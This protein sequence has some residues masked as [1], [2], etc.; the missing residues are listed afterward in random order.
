MNAIG[1]YFTTLLAQFGGGP[2]PPE[3]NLVRFGLAA[4]FWGVL[5]LLA[6][7]RQRQTP[8]PRERWLMIG[9]G[10]AFF[11]DLF[12]FS[13]LSHR[14][15]TN[16]DHDA[17]CSVMV[18]MEHALTLL[19]MVLI[20]GAF[21]RYILDDALLARR[22]LALGFGMSFLAALTLFGWW[23]RRLAIDPTVRFHTTWMAWFLHLVAAI[24]IVAAIVLL[25]RERG[26][27]SN[28]VVL[29]LSMILVSECLVLVNLVT[30]RA[31][32][33]LLCPLGNNLYIWAIP[34]FGFVYLRE[35]AHEK[36]EAE[37]TL[38]S[39]RNHLEELVDDRTTALTA[40]N[41]RLQAEITERLQIERENK[42]LYQKTERWAQG[43]AALHAMSIELTST[44]DDATVSDMI[45]RQSAGLMGCSISLLYR[46][47]EPDGTAKLIALYAGAGSND[48]DKPQVP[49]QLK[50]TLA[51]I[52]TE[53]STRRPFRI[54]PR[55]QT[56]PVA[57]E[58][59]SVAQGQPMIGVSLCGSQMPQHVLVL[60]AKDGV[61]SWHTH[62][63]DLLENYAGQAAAALEN[64][65]LHQ[66]LELAATLE[67]RQR[68]AA[69]MHDGLAQNLS[70]LGLKTDR[71]AQSLEDGNVQEVLDEFGQIRTI[72]GR[73][74][75]D[76]RRSISSLQ[77]APTP[78]QSLYD[79]LRAA[80]G[81]IDHV[82]SPSIKMIDEAN[83][84]T[85]YPPADQLDHVVRVVA[86]ALTNA[87]RHADAQHINIGIA[88]AEDD[89]VITVADDGKGFCLHAPE[90]KGA[91]HF[92]LSIMRAR[93]ARIHGNLAVES[94]PGQGTSVTLTW[95]ET[96][97]SMT[98]DA[99]SLTPDRAAMTAV[100]SI[101]SVD[102]KNGALP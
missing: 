57:D 24:L 79:A 34:V 87:C 17:L 64:A 39:Y 67:E 25:V 16:A 88:R 101:E 19:S 102:P 46:W 30:A 81:A 11:R 32:S 10:L 13:H 93:A 75:Q 84:A 7:S 73:T 20:S 77:S 94:A 89:L 90:T 27:L 55:E 99:A 42:R 61:E 50:H 8:R 56:A 98:A 40:S 83:V 15:I 37:A 59:G 41:A 1:D 28:V 6:W 22:Y 9:F 14:L 4:T 82:D 92:G 31:Y 36:E 47:S 43:M 80:I 65:H 2:G 70:Y 18:P 86:E 72:I 96:L 49:Q 12:M 69:E 63:L 33:G 76:V 91:G 26:W 66:R 53:L 62:D 29:A 5:L 95:R 3:N 100:Y 58:W 51:S 44:L 38:Q 85:I 45:V 74:I 60:L 97:A 23:P 35:Q 68:I 54:S 48:I 71:A 52:Q 21:L 78:R